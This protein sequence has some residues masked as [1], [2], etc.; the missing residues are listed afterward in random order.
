MKFVFYVDM[1]IQFKQKRSTPIDDRISIPVS[2][3]MRSKID[4]LKNSYRID[5]NEMV[6]HFLDYTIKKVESGDWQNN[7]N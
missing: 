7:N 3:E 5:V 6:R 1:E 2:H 4:Q